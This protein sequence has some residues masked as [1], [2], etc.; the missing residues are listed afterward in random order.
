MGEMRGL[1]VV[2][3]SQSFPNKRYHCL[4]ALTTEICLPVLEARGLMS[5]CLS[6]RLV[7]SECYKGESGPCLSPRFQWSPG[8]LWPSLASSGLPPVSAFISSV[9]CVLFCVQISPFCQGTSHV[10]LGPHPLPVQLPD[11]LTAS[12][13]SLFPNK[14]TL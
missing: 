9:L 14:V 8:N 3:V 5:R 12:V 10:G 1:K 13:P 7:L 4:E 6:A 2:F 11:D